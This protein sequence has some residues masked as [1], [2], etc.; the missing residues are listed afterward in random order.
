MPVPAPDRLRYLLRS[1]S[2][3]YRSAVDRSIEAIKALHGPVAVFTS[4]GKDSVVMCHLAVTH[5]TDVT[6]VHMAGGLPGSEHIHEFFAQLGVPVHVIPRDIPRTIA[7]L[8]EIGLYHERSEKTRAG[9]ARKVAK[10][11]DWMRENGYRV[12]MI[13]MRA[14]ESL[15]RRWNYRARGLTYELANGITTCCPIAHWAVED[16][17]AYIVAN[18]VPYNERVYDAETHGMTRETIR[19]SSWLS[20]IGAQEGQIAWLRRHFPHEYAQLREHFP[21]VEALSR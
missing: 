6:L 4:W 21:Q 19:N 9:V 12:Q 5:R 13:G 1:R 20:T 14:E 7:W 15:G 11:S 17:W 8:K 18:D 16:V 10:L 3:A 2:R